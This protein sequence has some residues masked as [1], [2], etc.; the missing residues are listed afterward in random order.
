MQYKHFLKG[1]VYLH[2]WRDRIWD[3]ASHS[4]TELIFIK[5]GPELW[6]SHRKTLLILLIRFQVLFFFNRLTLAVEWKLQAMKYYLFCTFYWHF[7]NFF[8]SLCIYRPLHLY[9]LSFITTTGVSSSTEKFCAGREAPGADLFL[10]CW[11][12]FFKH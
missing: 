9:L 4:S 12:F 10:L 5:M 11:E 2:M 6:T 7:F 1:V 8:S 3:H